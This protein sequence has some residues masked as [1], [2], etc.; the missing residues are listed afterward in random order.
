MFGPDPTSWRWPTKNG[1]ALLG[2]KSE[3]WRWWS[4]AEHFRE[5]YC[6]TALETETSKSWMGAGVPGMSWQWRLSWHP[7]PPCFSLLPPLICHP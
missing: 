4:R 3:S 5:V 6:Q 7:P 1:L 2:W